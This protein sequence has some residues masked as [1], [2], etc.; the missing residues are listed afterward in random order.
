MNDQWEKEPETETIK[1]QPTSENV[2]KRVVA[3]EM[4]RLQKQTVVLGTAV[5]V[6]AFIVLLMSAFSLMV[7]LFSVSLI[8]FVGVFVVFRARKEI[9][10]LTTK[11]NL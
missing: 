9:Q 1:I 6:S 2:S 5:I 10:R 3:V 7:A 8:T 4:I 11:Y